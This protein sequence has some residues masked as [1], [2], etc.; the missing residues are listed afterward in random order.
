MQFS[1][2]NVGKTLYLEGYD[3]S[4]GISNFWMTNRSRGPPVIYHGA[5]LKLVDNFLFMQILKHV[6]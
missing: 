5:I 3:F 6:R 2:L 1:S 4:M